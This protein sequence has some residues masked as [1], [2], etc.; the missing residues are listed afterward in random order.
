MTEDVGL[1]PAAAARD[2]GL[3]LRVLSGANRGAETRLS[4][5]VWTIGTNEDADLTFAEPSLA[6]AHIRIVVEA[7]RAEIT[8]A[9]PGVIV[10]AAQ[11]MPGQAVSVE[12]LTPVRVGATVFA[13]GPSGSDWSAVAVAPEAAT[14]PPDRP[15]SE[16]AAPPQAIVTPQAPGAA[17]APRRRLPPIAAIALGV[18]AAMALAAWPGYRLL[19]SP[20]TAAGPAKDQ[21]AEVQRIIAAHGLAPAVT[22][23]RVDGKLVVSGEAPPG[24]DIALLQR[25]LRASGIAAVVNLRTAPTPPA[26][27]TLAEMAATVLRGY[28]IEG[29]PTVDGPGRITLRGYAAKD[30]AIRDAVERIRADIPNLQAINDEIATPER[31]RAFL[32]QALTA[33]LRRSLRIVTGPHA[34]LISGRLRPG[35]TA[36]WQ[37]AADRF[38]QKF[39]PDIRLDMRFATPALWAPYGV[40]LGAAPFVVLESGARL[41]IGDRLDGAGPI[42]AIGRRGV[43]VR[44]ASGEMEVPYP[45]KPKWVVV[46]AKSK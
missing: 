6:P 23:A 14:Q 4:D 33:D 34:L 24:N 12:A 46:E 45:V 43:W 1:A 27:A 25:D 30:A 18:L 2:A 36:S 31:A 7:A 29:R 40:E 11:L 15:S 42:V 10:G 16:A 21:L 22:V 20:G 8:V 28:G 35:D 39:D 9:A 26:D 32:E 38:K 41:K 44:A 37:A 17:V 19:L 3:V 13:I 5:G